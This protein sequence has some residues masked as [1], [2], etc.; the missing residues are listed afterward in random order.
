MCYR[1]GQTSLWHASHTTSIPGKPMTVQSRALHMREITHRQAGEAEVGRSSVSWGAL[2][3]QRSFE[4]CKSVKADITLFLGVLFSMTVLLLSM[5]SIRT[6]WL[7]RWYRTFHSWSASAYKSWTQTAQF[8]IQHSTRMS[9]KTDE[10]LSL[11]SMPNYPFKP[12]GVVWRMQG[13]GWHFLMTTSRIPAEDTLS[14]YLNIFKDCAGNDLSVKM[15]GN[16]L[17]FSSE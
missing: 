4:S 2:S 1:W 10:L 15:M 13:L 9:S 16:L 11:C 14:S 7:E 6:W 5:K 12:K 3:C 17:A 8:D